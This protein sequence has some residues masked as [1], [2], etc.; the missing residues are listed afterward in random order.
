[1]IN[2]LQLVTRIN[3]KLSKKLEKQI[4]T[5]YNKKRNQYYIQTWHGGFGVKFIEKEIEDSLTA[6]YVRSSKHDSC[7]GICCRYNR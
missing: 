4:K 1:M 3:N 6:K 7:N 5:L 2:S